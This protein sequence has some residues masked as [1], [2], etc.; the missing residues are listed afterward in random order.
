MNYYYD[1]SITFHNNPNR[2]CHYLVQLCRW[3]VPDR[4]FVT[5]LYLLHFVQLMAG[6]ELVKVSIF[7]VLR[8]HAEGVAL[9]THC[10]QADDVRVPQPRH[11]PDLL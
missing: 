6:Q 10:Q 5:R 9:H 1:Y 7:H 11:D 2:G 8:D 4:G 3:N